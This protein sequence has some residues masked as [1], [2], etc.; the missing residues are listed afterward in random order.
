MVFLIDLHNLAQ[1]QAHSGSAKHSSFYLLTEHCL[2]KM[3]KWSYFLMCN[4]KILVN[5]YRPWARCI[6]SNNFKRN[7]HLFLCI[8]FE[9]DLSKCNPLISES[10]ASWL[11][12]PRDGIIGLFHRHTWVQIK[13][14]KFCLTCRCTGNQEALLV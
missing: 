11:H 14:L 6:Y 5:V 2:F 10:G 13:V 9:I 7:S 1:L 4:H 12:L 8:F 3:F